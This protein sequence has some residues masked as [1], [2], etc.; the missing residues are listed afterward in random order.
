MN[1]EHYLEKI[2]RNA[3]VLDKAPEE[4]KAVCLQNI[5]W[6]RDLSSR[7]DL[8]DYNERQV[9]IA[10]IHDVLDDDY[11]KMGFNKEETNGMRR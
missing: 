9:A 11:K 7:L 5:K 2:E 1:E 8:L 10:K 6:A 3:Y 4:I